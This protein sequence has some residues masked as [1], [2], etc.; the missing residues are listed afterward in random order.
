MRSHGL[1]HQGNFYIEI[2]YFLKIPVEL[3]C[4]EVNFC[5]AKQ[6]EAASR[7]SS[8]AT[9]GLTNENDIQKRNASVKRMQIKLC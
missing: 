5:I 4:I 7:S 9:L 8:G 1:Y 6:E 2:N 3:C